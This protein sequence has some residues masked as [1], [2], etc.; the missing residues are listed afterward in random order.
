[1]SGLNSD[2]VFISSVFQILN[3]LVYQS[4]SDYFPFS[5]HL[6][7]ELVDSIITSPL[8][9]EASQIRVPYISVNYGRASEQCLLLTPVYLIYLYPLR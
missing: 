2:S 4:C 7:E 6:F 8:Y 1:M 3:I 5:V 9:L